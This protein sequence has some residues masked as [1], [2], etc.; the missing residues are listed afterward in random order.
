MKESDDL[1]PMRGIATENSRLK[2]KSRQY[3]LGDKVRIY[4]GNQLLVLSVVEV[5][6]GRSWFVD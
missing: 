2:V 6:L 4:V 3:D 5:L 1:T